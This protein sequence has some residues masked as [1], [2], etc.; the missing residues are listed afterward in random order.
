MVARLFRLR[1]RGSRDEGD[2]PRLRLWWWFWNAS[3]IIGSTALVGKD[4]CLPGDHFGYAELCNRKWR[5][6]KRLMLAITGIRGE[7]K[8]YS[9][10]KKNDVVCTGNWA[11]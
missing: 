9:K 10:I 1:Q 6:V 2:L 8:S 4:G 3:C 7:K 11:H 5:T